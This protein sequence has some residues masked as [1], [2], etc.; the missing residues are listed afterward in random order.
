MAPRV[1]RDSDTNPPTRAVLFTLFPGVAVFG[2]EPNYQGL[3][4][5]TY[6]YM[7]YRHGIGRAPRQ[8]CVPLTDITTI[9][10]SQK[11]VKPMQY[12]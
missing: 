10:N 5:C 3:H 2:L 1:R 4:S 11:L 8:V 12:A 6:P 7:L 9:A